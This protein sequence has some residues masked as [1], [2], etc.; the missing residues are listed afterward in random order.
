MKKNN[1][2]LP[3]NTLSEVQ[4]NIFGFDVSEPEIEKD[5]KIKKCIKPSYI[6]SKLDVGDYKDPVL[7]ISDEYTNEFFMDEKGTVI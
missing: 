3:T 4:K 5:R 1:K 7:K 6:Q 2:V